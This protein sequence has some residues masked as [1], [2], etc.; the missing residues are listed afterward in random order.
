MENSIPDK[1]SITSGLSLKPIPTWITIYGFIGLILCCFLIFIFGFYIKVPKVVYLK[2]RYNG[3]SFVAV[4][5]SIT[6]SELQRSESIQIKVPTETGVKT[7]FG[8]INSSAIRKIDDNMII[9]IVVLSN[10]IREFSPKIGS[11]IGQLVTDSTPLITDILTKKK[12][13]GI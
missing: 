9:P 5:D 11:Y 12:K 10:D 7:I 4:T 1:N 2:V 13:S 8:E 3:N 6:I